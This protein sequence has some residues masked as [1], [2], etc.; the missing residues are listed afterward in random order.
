LLQK[1]RSVKQKKMLQINQG[2]VLGLYRVFHESQTL[3]RELISYVFVIKQVHINMQQI[4][5]G[6]GVI[7]A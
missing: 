7:T 4:W 3:L 1:C 5:N 2:M 6:Y